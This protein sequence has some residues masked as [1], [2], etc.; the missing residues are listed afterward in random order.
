MTTRFIIQQK[1]LCESFHCLSY[2]TKVT[3]TN[4]IINV[5]CKVFHVLGNGTVKYCKLI[6]MS[7]W[8]IDF[9]CQLSLASIHN[10]RK[11]GWINRCVSLLLIEIIASFRIK[12][13]DLYKILAVMQDTG[14]M[15]CNR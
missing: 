7:I 15:I 14:S 5:Q 1:L 3:L 13:N 11:L 12:F 6:E 8:K 9:K 10:A 2:T 4:V